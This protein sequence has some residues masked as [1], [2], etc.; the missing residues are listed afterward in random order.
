V[1]PLS[2]PTACVS[3]ENW[4]PALDTCFERERLT[5]LAHK[6]DRYDQVVALG[7]QGLGSIE[8]AQRVGLSRRTIDRW[9]KAEAFPETKRHRSKAKQV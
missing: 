1:A 5:R 4:K 8:I 7:A 3:V 2:L 6:R 9:L